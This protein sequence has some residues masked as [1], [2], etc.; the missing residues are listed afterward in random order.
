MPDRSVQSRPHMRYLCEVFHDDYN[1]L[2][3]WYTPNEPL[4][5]GM[6][7]LNR[8]CRQ[9]YMETYVLPYS[10]NRF[11]FDSCNYLFNF[12]VMENPPRLLPQQREAFTSIVVAR[13]LPGPAILDM[14]PNLEHVHLMRPDI[15]AEGGHHVVVKNGKKRELV[16]S[17]ELPK[18]NMRGGYNTH[19][20]YSGSGNS[21]NNKFG[22]NN[23]SRGH[24]QGP[25][26][27][28]DAWYH[29]L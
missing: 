1:P 16:R 19:T 29:R 12:L 7:L 2:N 10:L 11:F 25:Q 20:G 21:Y 9:L 14:L 24:R 17:T 3:S 5:V 6:T 15:I 22:R 28:A 23:G 27:Y 8:V 26:G 13:Q 4:S 18:A